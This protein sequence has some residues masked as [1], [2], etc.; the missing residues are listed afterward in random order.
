MKKLLN[1]RPSLYLALNIVLGILISYTAI[2]GYLLFLVLLS[3]IFIAIQLLFILMYKGGGYFSGKG[4]V[5]L[6]IIFLAITLI[7]TCVSGLIFTT[8]ITDYD[9]KN[10]PDGE[11]TFRARVSEITEG[12][13][14]KSLVLTNLVFDDPSI[15]KLKHKCSLFVYDNCTV[16]LGDVVIITTVVT[17]RYSI[18]DNKFSATYVDK[19]IK[20]T[21]KISG[22]NILVLH[23]TMNIFDRANLFIKDSLM[24]GMGRQEF[25]VSYALLCGNSDFIDEEVLQSFRSAGVA[26]IFAVSGLHIGFFC[27]N[28]K[29]YMRQTKL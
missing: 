17:N 18:Y 4:L 13:N 20:Y 12:E 21:A 2:F 3:I 14:G 28:S 24:Q 25:G 15:G 27:S 10:L 5:K 29:F 7:M 19:G 22:E 16:K 23:N 11:Y 1:F 26:H 9:N 6:K 8:T